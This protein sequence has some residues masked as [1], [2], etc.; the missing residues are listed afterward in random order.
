MK[1][2]PRNNRISQKA[3][4]TLGPVLFKLEQ[5]GRHTPEEIVAAATPKESSIHE[6]FDW[7]DKSAAHKHRLQ[8][9][10]F[11][12]RSIEITVVRGDQEEKAP[13]FYSVQR[14]AEEENGRRYVSLPTLLEEPDTAQQILG[15]LALEVD[16]VNQK[17][18]QFGRL[19][20]EVDQALRRLSLAVAS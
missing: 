17:Y 12:S 1:F 15:R 20:P 13:L 6:F 9:A 19:F 4:D 2:H 14:D 7:N 10:R 18:E 5:E 8:Q 11:Y 3:A 16:R